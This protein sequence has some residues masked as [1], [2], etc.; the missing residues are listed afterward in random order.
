MNHDEALRLKATERYLLD[1]LDPEA[2]DQF[3]EHLFD[4]QDCALDVRAAAMF[5]EQTKIALTPVT[6]AT[7][8]PA[9]A[10]LGWFARLRPAFAVPVMALLLAIVGYQNLVTF[11]HMAEA[12][13]R[14]QLGPWAS[15]NV[16]TRGASATIIK[17]QPGEGFNLLVSIPP[18]ASYSSYLLELHNPAGQLKWSRKIP[19]SAPD[20]TR[21]LYIPGGSLEQGTYVLVVNGFTANGQDTSLGIYPIELQVQK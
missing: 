12:A 19:A 13:N 15:V 14:P 9:P 6:F 4:C 18:D 1:E 16:S 3:E 5:V 21:A 2:K 20:E 8:A 11:P 17:A 7:V 10:K